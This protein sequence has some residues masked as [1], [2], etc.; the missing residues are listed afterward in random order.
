MNETE[1]LILQVMNKKLRA[2]VWLG[3]LVVMLMG[4]V[5]IFL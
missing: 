4:C 2:I 1:A 5:N 3:A